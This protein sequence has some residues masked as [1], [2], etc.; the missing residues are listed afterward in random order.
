[1]AGVSVSLKGSLIAVKKKV[2]LG[3]LVTVK[4]GKENTEKEAPS[5][6][7]EMRLKPE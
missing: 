3:E 7:V 6:A 4:L 1:M 5:G 2:S